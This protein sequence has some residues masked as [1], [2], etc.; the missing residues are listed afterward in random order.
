MS[1]LV[2]EYAKK[3]VHAFL[4]YYKIS[5]DQGEVLDF[6]DHPYLVD[7]YSDWSPRMCIKKCAQVGISTTIIIKALWAAKN[8]GLDVIYSFPTYDLANKMVSSKVNRLISNNGIFQQWVQDKDAIQQK[9]VG[10]NMLYFQGTSNE[11]AAIALP[12]D[13]YIADEVDRSDLKNVELFSSRLQHSRYAWEWRFSNPSVPENGVDVWWQE[14]DQKEWFVRCEGCNRDQILSMDHIK[15]SMFV[16]EK[17]G[18]ELNRRKGQW[19]KRFRDCDMSG[20]HISSLMASHLSAEK[21]LKEKRDKP[22]QQFVNMILG[23]PYVGNGNYLPRHVLFSN[24]TERENPQDAP[25][26]IGVDTGKRIHFVVGNKYGIFYREEAQDYKPIEKILNSDQ[27]AIAVIDVGGD[28]TAPREL[29]DRFPG[30]VYLC[31][32][33]QSQDVAPKW[34][35][36]IGMVN[37][38][39]NKIIQL[40]VDEF[41]ER[42]IPLFG[43]KEEWSMYGD[44]WS[45]LYRELEEDERGRRRYIW[46]R[47]GADHL[48][49]ATCYWRLGMD[50]VMGGEGELIYP[51]QHLFRTT[52]MT[53]EGEFTR[54]DGSMLKRL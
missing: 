41:T 25:P 20:W 39:R 16:C 15:H 10:K 14:S 7:I 2:E 12:A 31:A 54:T 18:K 5:N 17:C 32:F 27:R 11:Q 36:D 22:E 19:I 4:D 9:R 28:Q 30:R 42:R 53:L 51:D 49:L 35:E 1:D 46:N 21:I 37:T 24:L 45:H 48:A 29:R 43:S 34:K 44:H 52:G 33:V 38:D 8:V 47:N 13:L 6:H 50:K 23:E 26:V 40:V 3:D